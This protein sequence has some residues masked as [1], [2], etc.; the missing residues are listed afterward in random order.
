M[1]FKLLLADDSITIQ[2]VV[3]IIFSSD[4][5]DLAIVNNGTGALEKAAEIV[6]DV[7]LVDTLMPGAS[8]YEVCEKIRRDQALRHI[9][10]LLLTGAF[11]PFNVEKASESGADDFISKP[12]ESQI[13]IDKVHSLI[14]LGK[15]RGIATAVAEPAPPTGSQLPQEEAN[16]SFDAPLVSESVISSPPSASELSPAPD[17]SNIWDMD[18]Q[19]DAT[20]APVVAKPTAVSAPEETPDDVVWQLDSTAVE[21]T[22]EAVAAAAAPVFSKGAALD[23]LRAEEVIEVSPDDDLWGAFELE[24]ID[25]GSV[26]PVDIMETYTIGAGDL[27]MEESGFPANEAP[28]F[29]GE[30]AAAP[31]DTEPFQSEEDNFFGQDGYSFTSSGSPAEEEASASSFGAFETGAP[32]DAFEPAAVPVAEAVEPEHAAPAAEGYFFSDTAAPAFE[33]PIFGSGAA[34]EAGPARAEEPPVLEMTAPGPGAAAGEARGPITIDE[35]QLAEVISRISREV[36][37]KVV[38]EVVPDLAEILIKEEIRKIK[39]GR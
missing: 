32:E 5:Y 31:A 30:I 36:I 21:G 38:W 35:Q 11:E 27:P 39:E 3:S 22:D 8:G 9:P 10:I 20:E 13:L 1:S 17:S 7:M 24:P 29:V 28:G 4:E 25:E 12:F 15:S 23:A 2:K 33:A 16:W 26:D 19:L 18:F 34:D 6:P 14:E 37:E